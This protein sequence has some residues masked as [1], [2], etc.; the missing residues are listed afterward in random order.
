MKLIY[1]L[2]PLLILGCSAERPLAETTPSDPPAT[3]PGIAME[4][5]RHSDMRLTNH[6]YTDMGLLPVADAI[7]DVPSIIGKKDKVEA[8]GEALI[9]FPAGQ[10]SNG[11][12]TSSHS[13]TCLEMLDNQNNSPRKNTP[14]TVGQKVSTGARYR[15][16]TRKFHSATTATYKSRHTR[17]HTKYF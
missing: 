1:L 7:L 16:R 12:D 17:R 3:A 11:S 13:S 5:M 14:V 2:I 4:I 10:N 9:S 8:R 6:I 15:V